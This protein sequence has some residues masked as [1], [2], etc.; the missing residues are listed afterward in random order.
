M[1]SKIMFEEIH[2]FVREASR[3][4]LNDNRSFPVARYDNLLVYILKGS[5]NFKVEEM[6]HNLARGDALIIRAGSFYEYTVK[7]DEC[8]CIFVDF[9]YTTA[10]SKT[11]Y[12]KLYDSREDFDPHKLI[13]LTVFSNVQLFNISVRVSN[14]QIFGEKLIEMTEELKNRSAYSDLK[15][16]SLM[17]A[18]LFDT[19]R[20]L[21]LSSIETGNNAGLVEEVLTYINEHS[22]ENLTNYTIGNLFA[23]HPNHVNTLVKKKTGYTLHNYL[24]VR[25]ISKALE[26][27]DK[28]NL[29]VYEI[30]ER[31]GFSE[32]KNF[33]RHFKNIVGITPHQYRKRK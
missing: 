30:S 15:C 21:R 12:N 31:C 13:E 19:A 24:V 25:R 7:S 2:P 1:R 28:T 14:F 18:V 32:S 4:V 16:S 26:M 17:T 29:P 10:R 22:E 9:D 5:V 8:S 3:C 33:I 23:L 27:I 6:T 11:P 20:R